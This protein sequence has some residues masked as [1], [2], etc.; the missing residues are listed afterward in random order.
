MEE[1]PKE[2][3][4]ALKQ[5][6]K[7]QMQHTWMYSFMP[8]DN[9]IFLVGYCK[10]CDQTVSALVPLPIHRQPVGF[11]DARVNKAGIPKWGCSPSE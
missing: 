11:S 4:E 9:T 5:K 2:L 1:L 8:S 6:E 10:V 3:I 7:A